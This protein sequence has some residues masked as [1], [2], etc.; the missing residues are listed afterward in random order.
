MVG[1]SEVETLSLP[2][3]VRLLTK[4]NLKLLYDNSETTEVRRIKLF[5]NFQVHM[6]IK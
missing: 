4:K 5:I 1:W 2:S 6:L 3:S